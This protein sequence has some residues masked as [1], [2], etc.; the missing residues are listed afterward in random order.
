MYLVILFI[1]VW[2]SIYSYIGETEY[3][4][5]VLLPT[6]SVLLS[7][8]TFFI[9]GWGWLGGILAQLGIGV[10]LMLFKLLRKEPPEA[11]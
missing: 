7:L 11:L 2:A 1:I 4:N 8:V 9:F 6:L 10:I 5:S 3:G